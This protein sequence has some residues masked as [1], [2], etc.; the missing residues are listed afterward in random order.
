[1]RL[2]IFRFLVTCFLLL[3]V[4]FPNAQEQTYP[5]KPIRVINPFVAGGGLDALLRPLAVK[6]SESLKQSIII[7]NRPGANGMIGTEMA[8]KA[9]ADGYT[10]LGG[11]TGAISLNAVVYPKLPFDPIKDF[12]PISIFAAQPFLLAVH[13]SVPAN[14]LA[15][16][17]ALV[18]S[19]PNEITYGTFGIA[20]SSHLATELFN[21]MAGTKMIHVPYK[22]SGQSLPALLSGEVNSSF[23]AL[24]VMGGHIRA[25]RL[26][27]L[28]IGSAKRLLTAP[29]I[30]TISEAGVPGFEAGSWYGLLAPANT[31]R[32][33]IE[34]LQAE[35]VKAVA[36]QEIQH[37]YS[38]GGTEPIG[39]TPE[40]FAAQIKS[41]MAKWGKVVKEAKV[42]AQ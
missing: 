34:K 41:D 26:R 21:M 25:K 20:S 40:E 8:A 27:A 11:T 1:M 14:T 29:D 3:F 31:P 18:K 28:G 9:I 13:P 6:M 42:T 33:I 19:R 17:I 7:D 10:I 12:S 32:G 5:A 37:V 35:V 16:F 36:T 23:D 15:E 30:P 24:Q 38:G 4:S 22:G 39:G 2:A